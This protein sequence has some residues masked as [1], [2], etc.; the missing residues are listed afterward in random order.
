MIL[1]ICDDR[2]WTGWIWLKI[3][4]SDGLLWTR[5]RTEGSIQRC[6]FVD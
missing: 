4:A 6:D 1:K 3:Q 5:W 2:P